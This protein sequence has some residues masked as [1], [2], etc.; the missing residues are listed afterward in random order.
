MIVEVEINREFF[1][2]EL[3]DLAKIKNKVGKELRDALELRTTVKLVEP[4]SLPRF[5]GKEKRV[6]DRREGI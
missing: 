5:E 4:G 3:A 1:S 6:I 2:G